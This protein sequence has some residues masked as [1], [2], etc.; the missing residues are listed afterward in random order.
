M[1]VSQN[2]PG[3]VIEEDDLTANAVVDGTSGGA[4]VGQ[5]SWGPVEQLVTLSSVDDLEA[6]FGKPNDENYADWFSSS[7]FLAYTNNLVQVRVVDEDAMNSTDDGAGIVIKNDTQFQIVSTT[8]PTGVHFAGKFPGTLGNSLA[9]SVCDSNGFASWQ[10][11]G[12]FDTAP[13]SSDSALA[14]GASQDELHAVVIDL[15][16]L[17]SGTVGSV[18]ESYP[19]LSKAKDAKDANNAPNF[20]P[21]VINRTSKYV[22]AL[23]PLDGVSGS[24]GG[25]VQHVNVTAGGTGYTTATVTFAAPPAGGVQAT[26]TAIATAGVITGVTIVNPGKGYTTAPVV[27][28]GGPGTGATGTSTVNAITTTVTWGTSLVVAGVPS[29]YSLLAAPQ[30]L[31]LTGG[32]DSTDVGTAELITGYTLFENAEEVDVN[33]VFTGQA[34]GDD[35]MVVVNQFVIDNVGIGRADGLVFHSPKLADVL[36]R[37]QSD[38]ATNVAATN[39]LIGRSTSYASM[40]SGW[41]LQYDKYNDKY[42][43]VPL[44]A[45]IAG[46]CARVDNN[47]D[48]WWS[49]AGYNRGGIKNVVSLAFNPNK[50]SRD[51]LYKVNVNPVVTFKTDGT[52]L[53]GDKTRQG[54]NSAFSYI[55]TRRLFNLLEK[56]IGNAA[57]YSMFEFNDQY[58]RSAFV[59]MVEPLLRTV[60]GRRG[61]EDYKL[62]CDE[63]NNTDDVIQAG[64]FVGSIFIKPQY[65]IQWV[66][67]NFVA[68]RR[69]VS[70]EEVVGIV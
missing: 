59:N 63:T 12:Q 64:E 56:T 54:K 43:W 68:V 3:V 2:S 9:V 45:D 46:L 28:F 62:I 38:A 34:G 42:R 47:Q 37:T 39:D 5:F 14:V 30:V 7:N 20:Y 4:T 21:N 1:A 24:V 61:M 36:N 66:K 70:F 18:L 35:N 44:N 41:K 33:L 26:G 27:T 55:G 8:G 48:A 49:P 40:D 11:K 22:R 65:S 25:A 51:A 16:G 57:K 29:A 67:L 6:Q 60:K 32:A 15:H 58:T 23:T 19:Y 53:F 52:I 17:F 31:N 50:T 10:Y 13:T 69:E